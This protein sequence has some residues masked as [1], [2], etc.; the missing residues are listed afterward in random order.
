MME[1]QTFNLNDS[2]DPELPLLDDTLSKGQLGPDPENIQYDLTSYSHVHGNKGSW[3][4]KVGRHISN[5]F[6][7][8]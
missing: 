6:S 4:F 7:R 1:V 3:T 5:C 8:C 2:V